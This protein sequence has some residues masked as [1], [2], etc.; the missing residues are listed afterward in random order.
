MRL[1]EEYSVQ[2]NLDLTPRMAKWAW[3]LQ[4]I[5][6]PTFSRNKAKEF[7]KKFV[8]AEQETLI[9]VASGKRVKRYFPGTSS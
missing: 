4:Q 6:H 1:V 5:K 3:R 2:H 9:N 8:E 7:I